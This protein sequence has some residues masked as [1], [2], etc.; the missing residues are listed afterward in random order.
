MCERTTGGKKKLSFS[1]NLFHFSF[2][3]KE[4]SITPSSE[5]LPRAV[6]PA[7]GLL[8]QRSSVGCSVIVIWHEGA[9]VCAHT[10]VLKSRFV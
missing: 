8:E 4:S 2:K 10:C 6:V 1:F 9:L 7:V 5:L 3:C